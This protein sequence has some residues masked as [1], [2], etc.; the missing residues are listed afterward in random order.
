MARKKK[1]TKTAKKRA[2]K[3]ASKR[4]KKKTAFEVTGAAGIVLRKA[5]CEILETTG[6]QQPDQVTFNGGLGVQHSDSDL[7]LDV[8]GRTDLRYSE[9]EEVAVKIHICLSAA[10]KV[11]RSPSD[12]ELRNLL[13]G[14]VLTS[15]WPYMREATAS[16]ASRMGVHGVQLPLYNQFKITND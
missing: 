13:Q 16:I 11:S 9:K 2:K 4:P 7:V 12:E 10:F 3:K 8:H 1:T 15:V 5:D 14:V 6:N